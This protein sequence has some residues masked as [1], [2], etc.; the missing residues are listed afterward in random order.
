MIYESLIEFLLDY[1]RNVHTIK[2]AVVTAVNLQANTLDAKILTK[3]KYKDGQ[4]TTFQDVFSVP[5]FILSANQGTA[6]ITLPISEGDNVLIFFSD[7]DLGTLLTDTGNTPASPV[8]IKTH[9][10]EPVLALPCFFTLPNAKPVTPDAVVIENTGTSIIVGVD[11][12]INI[13]ATTVN[14]TATTVNSVGTI[15]HTGSFVLNGVPVETHGHIEQGDGQRVGP[16][17]P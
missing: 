4:E 12:T 5:F 14:L 9:G 11:G 2:P 1:N 15:N 10:Y 13:Q 7:R 17:I 3:T 16:P 6:R 8:E